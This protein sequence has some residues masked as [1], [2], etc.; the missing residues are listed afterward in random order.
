MAQDGVIGLS[1]TSAGMLNTITGTATWN[2]DILLAAD[3]HRHDHSLDPSHTHPSWE[4]PLY[5]MNIIPSPE[6]S[7]KEKTMRGLFLVYVVDP[8]FDLIVAQFG[9][10]V[11]VDGDSA[12]MK[13]IAKCGPFVKDI[14]DLDFVV[15]K[16]G[17]IRAKREVQT[18]KIAKE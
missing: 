13:A 17:N 15:L 14:D 5:Q 16:L 11:A 10:A 7:P 8:E 6:E 4:P 12:K 2:G 3:G 1:T 18:V 9:P